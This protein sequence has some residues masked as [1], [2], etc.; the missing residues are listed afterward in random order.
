MKLPSRVKA[1]RTPTLLFCALAAGHLAG[2]LQAAEMPKRKAGLWEINTRMDG[3]PAMG[4]IQQCVDQKSDDLMQQQARKEQPN[5]SVIDV[6]NQGN[7]VSVHSVCKVQGSTATT[8][9]VFVGSFDA[10]YKG[11]HV[12]PL[13]STAAWHQGVEGLAGSALG[14][15]VQGWSET[16]RCDHAEHGREQPQGNDEGS[17]G[18]G[19]DEAAE[20]EL[21][22]GAPAGIRGRPASP[23]VP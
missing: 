23:Q 3:M 20:I 6:N 4:A 21:R 7:K 8:D 16:R 22:L 19:D 11:R 17:D 2:S 18:P 10:A 15:T 5:C 12:D 13:Q 1:L 9:G 14:R